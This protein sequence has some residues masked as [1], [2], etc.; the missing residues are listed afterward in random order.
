MLIGELA[1]Q[2]GLSVQ[3]VRFYE[4]EGLLPAPARRR[5]GYRIYTDAELRQLK[6]IKQAKTLGF[7]LKEVRRILD[8]RKRGLCPCDE[9]KTTAADHL[10]NVRK[11][12]RQLQRFERELSKALTLWKKQGD[13]PV[14]AN[15]ICHLIERTMQN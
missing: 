6:F 12:I 14:R 10:Q 2:S 1:K 9:V 15:A 13:Q 8:T 11:Q 3:T 5:S 4:R 7:T